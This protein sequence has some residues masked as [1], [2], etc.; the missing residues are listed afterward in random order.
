[1]AKILLYVTFLSCVFCAQIKPMEEQKG[2]FIPASF[3]IITALDNLSVASVCQTLSFTAGIA[4]LYKA[5]DSLAKSYQ[6]QEPAISEA[7]NSILSRN[8]NLK[9]TC[10]CYLVTGC[11]F[12]AAGL[13]QKYSSQ[14]M[15][16]IPAFNK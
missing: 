8:R 15:Q 13:L 16:H 14:L 5:A 6:L 3:R 11:A 2:L 9:K 12:T 7:G 1:M 10:F 4:L